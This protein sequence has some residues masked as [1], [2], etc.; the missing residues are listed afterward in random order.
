VAHDFD[1]GH[2][3]PV[4]HWTMKAPYFGTSNE[5]YD[6]GAPEDPAHYEQVESRR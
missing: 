4:G 3:T 1:L 6:A 5:L 2:L